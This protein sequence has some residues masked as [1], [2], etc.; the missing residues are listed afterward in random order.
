M[1]KKIHA[2]ARRYAKRGLCASFASLRL[3]VINF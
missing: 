1:I 3:C 2:K